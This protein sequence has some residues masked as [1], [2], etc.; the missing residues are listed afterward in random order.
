MLWHEDPNEF[1]KEAESSD[2]SVL[3]P[4]HCTHFVVVFYSSLHR[5]ILDKRACLALLGPLALD[6]KELR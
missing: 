1:K 4:L 6:H 2:S 5:V 3:S